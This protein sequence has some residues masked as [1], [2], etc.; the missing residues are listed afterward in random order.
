M[1]R[2]P[3]AKRA[4]SNVRRCGEWQSERKRRSERETSKWS[5]RETWQQRQ[6][7][8]LRILVA[9]VRVCACV[10]SVNVLASVLVPHLVLESS[11]DQIDVRYTRRIL[12]THLLLMYPFECLDLQL[13]VQ[14]KASI[15]KREGGASGW[16]YLLQSRAQFH[17]L[18]WPQT[19]SDQI[20]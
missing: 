3:A 14:L 13:P 9:C 1:L 16:T 2:C 5:K 20:R 6:K 4:T 12:V 8:R 17:C 11:C 7:H 18:Q 10:C 19:S 15:T